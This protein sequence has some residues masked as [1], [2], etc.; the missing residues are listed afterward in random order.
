MA[1]AK[2]KEFKPPKT[3]A[4]CADLMY[5]TRE[6]RYALQKEVDELARQENILREHLINTLPKGDA[7]GTTGKVANATIKSKEVYAAKDWDAIW[8]YIFANHKKNPGV[9]ALVQKRLGEGA[10]KEL[11]EAGKLPKGIEM[12]LVPT[13]SLTKV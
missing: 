1:T 3:L 2:P 6:R 4:Q 10:A 13:V 9:T 7:T 11:A 5:T 8:T 12:V